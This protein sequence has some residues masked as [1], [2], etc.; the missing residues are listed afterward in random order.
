MGTEEDELIAVRA[1]IATLDE[2][3]ARIGAEVA[4]VELTLSADVARLKEELDAPIE[5]GRVAA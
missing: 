1:K 4:A 5:E 3:D 2:A